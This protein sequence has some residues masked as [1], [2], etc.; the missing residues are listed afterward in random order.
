PGFAY[1]PLKRTHNILPADRVK[2][3]KEV[4]RLWR[5]N[6]K[7]LK[8]YAEGEVQDILFIAEKPILEN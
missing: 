1:L 3:G 2:K 7:E 6:K 5:E 4:Y 8:K